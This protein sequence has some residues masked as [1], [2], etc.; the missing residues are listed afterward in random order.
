MLNVALTRS[1][2]RG[3]EPQKELQVNQFGFL[4]KKTVKT[5]YCSL[6]SGKMVQPLRRSSRPN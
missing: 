3:E 4:G 6:L 5:S 1:C 2:G